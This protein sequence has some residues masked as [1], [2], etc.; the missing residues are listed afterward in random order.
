[1]DFEHGKA[2][3]SRFNDCINAG[4]IEGLS[5]AMTD[6]HVFI[7]AADKRVSGKPACLRAWQDFFAA[8]PD[9]RNHFAQFATKQEL[10]VVAGR[11]SC[12]DQRLYGPALWTA[13]VRGDRVSEWRVL[14]DNASNR[15]SLSLR[16]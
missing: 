6:D 7:D 9:Y 1:M 2:V 4:D 5:R 15:Y 3:V 8:F 14:E 12:S 13:R 10:I 11:S 16:D